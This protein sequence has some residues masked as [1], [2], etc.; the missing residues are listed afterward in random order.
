MNNVTNNFRRQCVILLLTKKMSVGT[1]RCEKKN[2]IATYDKKYF[3]SMSEYTAIVFHMRD[4][5]MT[6]AKTIF[7]NKDQLFIMTTF[8]S[9]ANIPNLTPW[10][11]F[12][13]EFHL[14]MTYRSDSDIYRKFGTFSPIHPDAP[15]DFTKMK[16][17]KY[18]GKEFNKTKDIFWTV[19][20]CNTKGGRE[21]YIERM[22]KIIPIDIYGRCGIHID[23]GRDIFEK[24]GSKYKFYLSFENSIC[25]EYVT[26]K[27]YE[28]IKN[29]Y[30]P[31]V[32]GGMDY[33]KIAPKHSYINALDFK[34]PEDL[35]YYLKHLN[36]NKEE[37]Y[38]YFWW[39]KYYRV[40][41]TKNDY[42]C[43]LAEKIYDIDRKSQKKYNDLEDW[44]IGGRK[45]PKSCWQLK[46]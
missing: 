38:S 3:K 41:I 36:E 34:S 30:L 21:K 23:K 10:R 45:Y 4:I 9:P 44:W 19:S 18:T 26:E 5:N 6:E 27:F 31:V 39:K 14:T 42:I 7:G 24:I 40:K 15:E 1:Q 8:E 32:F 46:F 11:K 29:D 12:K 25:K 43:E 20:H 28:N 37:Y 35:A 2:C 22:K 13:K 33:S 17:T 16:V